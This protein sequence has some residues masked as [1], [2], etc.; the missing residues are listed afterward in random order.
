MDIKSLGRN[1]I[2][3]EVVRNGEVVKLIK[4]K[5]KGLSINPEK[6][7]VDLDHINSD[8]MAFRERI[9]MSSEGLLILEVG[10]KVKKGYDATFTLWS[11]RFEIFQSELKINAETCLNNV[12]RKMANKIDELNGLLKKIY[13]QYVVRNR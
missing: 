9:K 2:N 7:Y 12:S 4:L 5:D 6:L 13:I 3:A 1:N 8:N 11:S 10:H